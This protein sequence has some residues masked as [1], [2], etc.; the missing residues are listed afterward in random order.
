MLQISS[1]K[2]QSKAKISVFVLEDY[3]AVEDYGE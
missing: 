3:S 2:G 1:L